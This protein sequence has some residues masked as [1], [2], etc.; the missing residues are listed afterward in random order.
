[1]K[2]KRA[3]KKETRERE[4]KRVCEESGTTPKEKRQYRNYGERQKK[5]YIDFIVFCAP[6]FFSSIFTSLSRQTEEGAPQKVS[7]S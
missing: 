1:M 2:T 5:I 4:R 7:V 3:K 6:G